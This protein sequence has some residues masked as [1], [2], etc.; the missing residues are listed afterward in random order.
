MDDY[1]K[2]Y[3]AEQYAKE[4]A[5]VDRAEAYRAGRTSLS[6]E[7][8]AHPDYAAV[9]NDMRGR[10]ERHEIRRDL[11]EVLYAYLNLDGDKVTTW[12]GHWLGHAWTAP[13]YRGRMGDVR[14]SVDT[15]INGQPYSGTCYGGRGC[16]VRL[17]RVK[18]HR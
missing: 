15:T 6:R 1:G 18:R 13:P 5:L 2:S 11:P 3:T 8:A 9:D 12:P 14:V 4:R 7:E 10:V 17:R 16:Y